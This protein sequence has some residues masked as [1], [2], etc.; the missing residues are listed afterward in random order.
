MANASMKWANHV[1]NILQGLEASEEKPDE[2]DEDDEEGDF[3]L[4]EIKKWEYTLYITL[5]LR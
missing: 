5:H 2:E 3:R 4:P 1:T